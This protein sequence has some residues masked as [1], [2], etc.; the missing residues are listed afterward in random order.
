[1]EIFIQS[2]DGLD[3]LWNNAGVMFPGKVPGT[4]QGDEMHLGAN[5]IAHL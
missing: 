4:I 2:E 3:I 1:M 5:T